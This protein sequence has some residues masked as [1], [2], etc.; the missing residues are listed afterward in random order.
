MKIS[1]IF[2]FFSGVPADRG[3]ASIED[4]VIPKPVAPSRFSM[5][6]GEEFSKGLEA[7]G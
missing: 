5:V 4:L 3:G 1:D 6:G 7:V 2:I